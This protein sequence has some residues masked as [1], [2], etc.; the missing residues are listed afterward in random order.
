MP[1]AECGCKCRCRGGM[2]GALNRVFDP[3]RPVAP[4]S[5]SSG[6]VDSIAL[7]PHTT[8]FTSVFSEPTRRE[9]REARASSWLR[10]GYVLALSLTRS[11]LALRFTLLTIGLDMSSRLDEE[12]HLPIGLPQLLQFSCSNASSA[13]II[14]SQPQHCSFDIGSY[15]SSPDILYLCLPHLR[16]A[17]ACVGEKIS[18]PVVDRLALRK[19]LRRIESGTVQENPRTTSTAMR[20]PNNTCLA[21]PS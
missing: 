5:G 9:S 2:Q 8:L 20:T 1:S 18:T 7:L 4:L 14:S 21:R 12:I 11:G 10:P 16:H 6:R 17:C 19:P 13:S 3:V 15:S